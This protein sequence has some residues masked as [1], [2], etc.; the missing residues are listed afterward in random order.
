M[1]TYNELK[2]A[3]RSMSEEDAKISMAH[4]KYKEIMH[5]IA[6]ASAYSALHSIHSDRT[7]T[8]NEATKRIVQDADIK[9]KEHIGNAIKLAGPITD[10]VIRHYSD[11]K[12]EQQKSFL[13]IQN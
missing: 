10:N 9:R 13:H 5:H 2:K 1:F 12:P 11:L 7:K 3:E 8:P 6:N 4:P